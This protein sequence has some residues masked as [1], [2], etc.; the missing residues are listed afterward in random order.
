[1]HRLIVQM[2]VPI[3]ILGRSIA[4]STF[5]WVSSLLISFLILYRQSSSISNA[6]SLSTQSRDIIPFCLSS[7]PPPAIFCWSSIGM[8]TPYLGPKTA[9]ATRA[10]T[11][12]LKRIG[13]TPALSKNPKVYKKPTPPFSSTEP[14]SGLAYAQ[15]REIGRISMYQKTVNPSSGMIQHLSEIELV[16]MFAAITM[17]HMNT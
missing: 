6:L 5:P 7:L 17:K 15:H 13:M 3:T 1:M 8:N 4:D 11:A 14:K 10:V 2:K 9:V 12:P 16:A